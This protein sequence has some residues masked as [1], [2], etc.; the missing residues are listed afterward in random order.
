ML[1]KLTI[2]VSESDEF[3]SNK[4][5]TNGIIVLSNVDHDELLKTDESKIN[6]EIGCVNYSCD[7]SVLNPGDPDDPDDPENEDND[8]V[9]FSSDDLFSEG[10]LPLSFSC[11]SSRSVIVCY[12][13]F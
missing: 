12:R 9:F 3:D 2:E 11:C 1:L 5:V 4:H 13:H 10:M 8:Q 7:E 6:L